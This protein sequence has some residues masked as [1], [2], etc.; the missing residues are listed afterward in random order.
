MDVQDKIAARRKERAEEAEA[1]SEA[2]RAATN[3]FN[4]EAAKSVGWGIKAIS[5]LLILYGFY[6]V[7]VDGDQGIVL[8][9]AGFGLHLGMF[10]W[11]RRKLMNEAASE[12]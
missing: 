8:V 11:Q 7:V 3:E 4:V 9:V 6:S 12:G 2:A 5:L 1:A 10:Y